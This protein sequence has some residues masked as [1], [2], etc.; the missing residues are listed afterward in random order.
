MQATPVSGLSDQLRAS[1]CEVRK[2]SDEYAPLIRQLENVLEAAERGGLD[3]QVLR[4]TQAL[5]LRYPR[6]QLTRAAAATDDGLEATRAVL[7]E[8]KNRVVSFEHEAGRAKDEP[9]ADPKAS[10]GR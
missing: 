10:S 2:A 5:S 3:L 7:V 8:I 4:S 1:L 6:L 9:G